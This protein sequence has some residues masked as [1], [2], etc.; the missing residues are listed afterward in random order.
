MSYLLHP[1]LLD[2]AGLGLALRSYVEGFSARSGIDV[3]VEVPD[4]LERLPND[5]EL[6][7]FRVAQ[8]ALT[9]VS[10]HSES[11]IA[12]IRLA[13][14]PSLDGANIVMTIENGQPSA[15]RPSQVRSLLDGPLKPSRGVGLASMRERLGQIGGH[16]DVL[17]AG[18]ATL[19]RATI[20]LLAA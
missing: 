19:V 14:E 11:K 17:S 10:R 16:L 8:E 1:P 3:D 7:L 20:P 2:E 6:V 5:V 12:H 4:S 13:R 15:A 18:G 9:N